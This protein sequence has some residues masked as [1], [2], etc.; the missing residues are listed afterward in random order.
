MMT[1]GGS[2]RRLRMFGIYVKNTYYRTNAPI[3]SWNLIEIIIKTM[4]I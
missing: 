4:W 2:L 3:I 1:G